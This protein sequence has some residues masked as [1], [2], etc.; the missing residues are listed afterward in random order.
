MERLYSTIND[1][2]R[3]VSG[4]S[5]ALRSDTNAGP[6]DIQ[7]A[8]I[9]T[10]VAAGNSSVLET[11]TNEKIQ[12]YQLMLKDIQVY[13][14]LRSFGVLGEFTRTFFQELEWL[15]D[16]WLDDES[17]ELFDAKRVAYIE[18]R[19]I[20]LPFEIALNH[21]DPSFRTQS[22]NEIWLSVFK[23]PAPWRQDPSLVM[24]MS[25]EDKERIYAHFEYMCYFVLNTRES[26]LYDIQCAL[27][28]ENE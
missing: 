19:L 11:L 28:L 26:L 15:K 7:T 2:F 16:T 18:D 17:E 1:S 14:Q 9:Q 22:L 21:V 10:S 25:R 13:E 20:E 12:K 4:I 3:L 6:D 8:D 23:E 5:S 27:G 24:A